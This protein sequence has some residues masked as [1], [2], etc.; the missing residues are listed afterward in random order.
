M[1]KIFNVDPVPGSAAFDPWIQDPGSGMEKSGSG[2]I[3]QDPQQFFS[4]LIQLDYH[5]KEFCKLL[6]LFFPSV[7]QLCK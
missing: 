7:F 5:H 1:L 2:I 6:E 4:W 3:A